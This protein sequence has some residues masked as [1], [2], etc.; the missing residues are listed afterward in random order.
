MPCGSRHEGPCSITLNTCWPFLPGLG[1]ARP[2]GSEPGTQQLGRVQAG[3]AQDTGALRWSS[4]VQVGVLQLGTWE[5]LRRCQQKPP[6]PSRLASPAAPPCLQPSPHAA[7]A[8]GHPA[9]DMSAPPPRTCCHRAAAVTQPL[10]SHSRHRRCD[11]VANGPDACSQRC[12]FASLQQGAPYSCH[13]SLQQP[14]ESNSQHESV[15]PRR[16]ESGADTQSC[17]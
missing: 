2:E 5:G 9:A 7:A 6:G 3:G 17:S 13:A 16:W 10:L 4:N 14:L 8:A 15:R 11:G 1:F 12:A